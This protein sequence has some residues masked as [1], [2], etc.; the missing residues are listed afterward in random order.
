MNSFVRSASLA[1][2]VFQLFQTLFAKA[3]VLHVLLWLDMLRFPSCVH[4][5]RSAT[6]TEKFFSFQWEKEDK[7]QSQGYN[8]SPL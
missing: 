5:L 4:V 2:N 7:A 1:D 3:Y 6:S 8:N